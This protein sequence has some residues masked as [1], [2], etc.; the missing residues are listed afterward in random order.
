[1][2]DA[3]GGAGQGPWPLAEDL[4][5]VKAFVDG[6]Q[7]SA[8]GDWFRRLAEDG[9]GESLELLR[10]TLLVRS[11]DMYGKHYFPRVAAWALIRRGPPG[12]A[13]LGEL[14]TSP[15]VPGA[16]Y[17]QAVIDSLWSAS[18]GR[19]TRL[20]ETAAAQ[21]GGW[22]LGSI[23]LPTTEAAR[24]LIIDL[25]AEIPFDQRVFDRLIGV[26]DANRL[27][28][29]DVPWIQND[30]L[31][32]ITRATIKISPSLLD[33]FERMLGAG[34]PEEALACSNAGG[35][36]AVRR[37]VRLRAP[38]RLDRLLRPGRG[39]TP[40]MGSTRSRPSPRFSPPRDFAGSH[41]VMV[42][43]ERRWMRAPVQSRHEPAVAQHHSTQR[44]VMK[45]IRPDPVLVR[46]GVAITAGDE[47]GWNDKREVERQAW[48]VQPHEDDERTRGSPSCQ[49]LDSEG[50]RPR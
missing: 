45:G 15:D 31:S 28:P 37:L 14:S 35:W 39:S 34:L 13:V 26:I 49:K 33:D 30:F 50:P 36:H 23:D 3:D 20:L 1:M 24:R 5:S 32:L 22:D 7:P 29:D 40:I 10:A 47:H 9:T 42:E 17:P 18:V 27:V 12:V 6:T 43:I 4:D 8:L 19:W 48:P 25:V 41:Y 2:D 16:I 11:D 46:R 44:L 38:S 21:M